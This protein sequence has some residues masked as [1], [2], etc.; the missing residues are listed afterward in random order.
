MSTSTISETSK[1]PLRVILDSNALFVPFQLKID[2]FDELQKL[3]NVNFEMVILSPVLQEIEKLA[4]RNSPKKRKEATC[5][6]ELAKRC[7]LLEVSSAKTST[8]SIILEMAH[9]LGCPV[10][11]NDK[12]L[13]KRLR[14]INVPVIYVRQKSYL[15]I[16]GRP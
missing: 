12:P 15:E 7:K 4:Q 5:A 6:L 16:D 2:I 9:E 11:T 8:D 3:L 14:N 13:R 10:F 1:Q